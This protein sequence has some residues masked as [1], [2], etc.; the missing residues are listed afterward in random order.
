[1]PD[2]IIIEATRIKNVTNQSSSRMQVLLVLFFCLKNITL[3]F[4]TSYYIFI[5]SNSPPTKI[6]LIETE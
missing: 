5:S 4:N 2:G 3:H 1:M 6:C